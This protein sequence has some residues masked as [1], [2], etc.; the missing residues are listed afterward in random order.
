MQMMEVY[1]QGDVIDVAEFSFT[2]SGSGVIQETFIEEDFQFTFEATNDAESK[3]YELEETVSM[4]GE[5]FIA[6][7]VTIHPLRTGVK[8][9]EH[10][11]NTKELLSIEGLE[12]KGEGGEVWSSISNGVSA[13]GGPENDAIT[14]YLQSNYFDKPETLSLSFSK[15]MVVDP[16]QQYMEL[17]LQKKAD[18][19]SAG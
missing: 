1:T 16:E 7:S 10:P 15:V 12:L 3:V 13:S 5:R 2:I 19:L 11:D 4:E 17:D 8:V 6:E 18:Y 14:F 9:R